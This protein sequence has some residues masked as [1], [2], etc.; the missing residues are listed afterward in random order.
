MR[1]YQL[2]VLSFLAAAALNSLAKP[3]S[4][5]WHDMRVKH[6]W[7]TIPPNWETLGHPPPGTTINL[8]VAL[9]PHREHALIDGLYDVSDPKSPKHVLSNPPPCTM[10]S[11]VSLFRCSYG[12]HLSKQQVAQLVAPH[13]DTLELV[14]SWL[15]HHD[16]PSSSISTTHSGSCLKVTGVPVYQANELLGASYQ[17]YRRTGTNDT[18]IVR[19]IGYAL[20]EVL[21]KHVRTIMPTT[22]FASTRK[23]W[24]EPRR[25]SVGTTVNTTSRDLTRTLSSRVDVDMTPEEL[26]WLYRTVYYVPT[27]TDKN[28]LG[29]AGFLN[30]YPSPA[31]LTSFMIQFR[32]DAVDATV[33]VDEVNGGDYDPENPGVEANLDLQYTEAIAYPTPHVFYSTGGKLYVKHGTNEPGEGDMWAEWLDYLL[34]PDL[35]EDEVPKTISISYGDLEFYL[36]LAYAQTLCDMFAQL[37]AL[38]VSVLCPSGDDGVGHGQCKSLDGSVQFVPEWPSSCMVA[39]Y[40]SVKAGHFRGHR[41]LTTSQRFFRS[42]GH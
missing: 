42:L 24:Q 7:K 38:G 36:P 23:L 35:D 17:L 16:V 27:A 12:A 1:S 41:L 21:H 2:S 19:T 4:P 33:F 32:T 14:Y 37:G 22:Y 39:F 11:Q 20:P 8:Y 10:Y 5:P 13:P 3:P 40:F 34:D 25:R 30:Q 15:E 18:T 31:D 26:R 29:V 6:T 9:M 28:A